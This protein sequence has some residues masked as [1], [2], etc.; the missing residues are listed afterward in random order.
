MGRGMQKGMLAACSGL[1]ND[2]KRGICVSGMFCVLNQAKFWGEVGAGG[3]VMYLK[4]AMG[5]N[6]SVREMRTAGR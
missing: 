3:L 1:V 4:E 6:P 2:L 5:C